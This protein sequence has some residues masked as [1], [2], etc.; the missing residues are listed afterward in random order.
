MTHHRSGRGDVPV[1][2][3]EGMA[4]YRERLLVAAERL[5][6]IAAENLRPQGIDVTD[7][8]R[9]DLAQRNQRRRWGRLH[10]RHT[11]TPRPRR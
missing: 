11:M 8:N 6:V 5:K 7:P 4:E 1:D 9:R 2:E 10:G 3:G